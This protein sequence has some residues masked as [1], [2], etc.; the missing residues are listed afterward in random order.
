MNSFFPRKWECSCTV[1]H[2][3]KPNILFPTQVGV[4]PVQLCRTGKS[5]PFSHASGSVPM[6][7]IEPKELRNFFPRKWECST[8]AQVADVPVVFFPTQVGVFLLKGLKLIVMSSFPTQVGVFRIF[9]FA[10]HLNHPF[11]HVSGSVPGLE[12][13]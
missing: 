8:K 7:G 5:A 6:T 11:S 10:V 3:S 13:Y 1:F 9:G 2:S 12:T 4:F